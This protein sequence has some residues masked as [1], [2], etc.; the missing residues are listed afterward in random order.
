MKRKSSKTA[1]LLFEMKVGDHILA[2]GSSASLPGDWYLG[3]VLWT[4]GIDVLMERSTL[5]GQR[6]RQCESVTCIRAVGTIA[7]LATLQ[8]T[9]RKEVAALAARVREATS[10]L[11]AARGALWTRVAELAEGGLKVIP[12]PGPHC[13]ENPLS[14]LDEILDTPIVMEASAP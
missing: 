10:E 13:D 11:G 4:N 8:E 2:G 1:G 6:F 7:E 5:N 9:C 12:N 3:L 14:G